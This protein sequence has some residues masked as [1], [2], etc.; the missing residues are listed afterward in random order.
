VYRNRG[1]GWA[2]L[3]AIAA[4][5]SPR[6]G[7]TQKAVPVPALPPDSI[8]ATL[9]DDSSLVLNST[10]LPA[11]FVRDVVALLFVRGTP[12]PDRQ[13]AVDLVNGEVIGGEPFPDGDGYYLVR[14]PGD[15]TDGPVFDAIARLEALPQVEL[16]TL[17]MLVEEP[18]NYLRPNDGQTRPR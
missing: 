8:P 11:P 18:T 6:S 1:A 7:A 2:L 9:Y 10:R 12:Q 3:V 14:V 5:S 4:G 13:A 16:A 17:D 15:G